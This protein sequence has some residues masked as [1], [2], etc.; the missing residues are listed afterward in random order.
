MFAR[1]LLFLLLSASLAMGQQA[2]TGRIV[3][4]DPTSKVYRQL[5]TPTVEFPLNG[6]LIQ[7]YSQCTITSRDGVVLS[8]VYKEESAQPADKPVEK[9]ASP[10]I[11]EIRT[12]AE[13]GDAE[14]QYLLAYCLQTGQVVEQNY[15]E[16]VKW[17][18]KS[19]MQG[20]MP[21]QHNLG[22]L[23]MTGKGVGQDYGEAYAWALLA[24]SNGNDSL[25]KALEYKLSN[26]QKKAGKLRAKQIQSKQSAQ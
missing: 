20:H 6:K 17:Y 2:D 10:S 21:S 7:T 13:Q 19:A 11:Q 4:G 23:H 3:E 26:E 14:S 12:Q 25:I 1:I 24:A 9:N 15:E 8:A 18:T 5:G 22:F 16:A